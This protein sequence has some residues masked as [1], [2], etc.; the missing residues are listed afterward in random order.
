M[1]LKNKAEQA[2]QNALAKYLMAEYGGWYQRIPDTPY[3]GASNRKPFDGIWTALGIA[4]ENKRML[5]GRIFNLKRWYADRPNQYTGLMQ[6]H[7]SHSGPAVLVI[8]WKPAKGAKY[9]LKWIAVRDIDM[10]KG[11]LELSEMQGEEMFK[12]MVET[13]NGIIAKGSR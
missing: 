11:Y 5:G 7:R 9:I 1:A 12:V 6:F 4:I 10:D 13:I 8:H 2:Q 3:G